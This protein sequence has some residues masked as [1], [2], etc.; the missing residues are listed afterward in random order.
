MDR[1]LKMLMPVAKSVPTEPSVVVISYEKV[2]TY[3]SDMTL[4][5]FVVKAK[6]LE[7]SR[8]IKK[9]IAKRLMKESEF[10]D[11]WMYMEK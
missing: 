11:Q 8:G 1:V 4:N 9:K 5:R 6:L 7:T 10:Q 2:E 3:A